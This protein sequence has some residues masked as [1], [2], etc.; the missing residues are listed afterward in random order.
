MNRIKIAPEYSNRYLQIERPKPLSD[1]NIESEINQ[2]LNGNWDHD[3][4]DKVYSDFKYECANWLLE[5]KLNR[6]TGLEKFNRIDIIN[7]CTQ[8]IDNIYISGPVQTFVGDYR[9]HERLGVCTTLKNITELVPR[10]PLIISLPFPNN[11]KIHTH[12]QEIL[13]RCLDLDIPVHIDSAWISA[14]RD[15]IFDYSHP[16]IKSV[17]MSLSK[18]LGLGW[19]RVGIRW[20]RNFDKPD[21]I[22]I[23]NDF[24]MNMRVVAKIGLHFIRN[25]PSD[26]LW[27]NHG[28]RYHKVCNDFNLTATN[29]I[30][31]A[32]DGY[33]P[34]GVS[35][36]IRYLENHGTN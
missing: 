30:H 34:V 23:M 1:N 16:S 31:L 32:L 18:G 24:N 4:S 22:S 25:F 19:N 12:M 21:S 9:Y 28:E 26:Y 3:I 14:S 15:I 27:N 6:L 33:S 7:G 35:P 17:G 29:S 2:I 8:F 20:L 36:L 11:G 10:V 13:D 5:S